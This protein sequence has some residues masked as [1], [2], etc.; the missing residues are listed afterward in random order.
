MTNTQSI[1]A[2]ASD[3][4]ALFTF[5]ALSPVIE[6]DKHSPLLR[7]RVA[8]QSM[9]ITPATLSLLAGKCLIVRK[10]NAIHL[11]EAGHQLVPQNG[12]GRDIEITMGAEGPIAFNRNESPLSTL[13]NRKQADGTSFLKICEYEAGERVRADFTRAMLMPRT[14]ANWQATAMAG[15]RSGSCNGVEDIT[16]SAIAARNRLDTALQRLGHDLS[17]VVMDICCFLKG[18]EQVEVERRWP[19]RSAK[20]MLKAALATLAL[21]YNPPAKPTGKPHKW[22]SADYRPKI[23]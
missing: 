22:G 12:P 5:L 13:A 15:R 6:Q 21:H 11:T 20:F 1:D 17:G 3:Y 18:F 16:H 9:T 23:S 14:T 8:D 10:A 2:S 7:L 19:K 4:T